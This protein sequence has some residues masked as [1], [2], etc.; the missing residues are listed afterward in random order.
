MLQTLFSSGDPQVT[1]CSCS[2]CGS[3]LPA[4]DINVAA[5]VALCRQCGAAGRFSELVQNKFHSLHL[6]YP[7]SG[8]SFQVVRGGFS[9]H[10]TTRSAQAWFLVPFLMVWSGVSLNGIY[11]TQFRNGRFDPG[12]SLFGLPFVAGTLLFGAQALMYVCGRI[13]VK[14]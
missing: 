14:R 8:T 1:T 12:A 7:P 9:A 2:R 5:D 3:P 4:A 6:A 10:A 13:V 11:G